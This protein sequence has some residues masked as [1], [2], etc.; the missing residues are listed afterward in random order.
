MSLEEQVNAFSAHLYLDGLPV[1]LNYQRLTRRLSDP[2]IARRERLD[3][4]VALAS[5]EG[6]GFLTLADHEDDT[7]L[8][9]RFFPKDRTY[10]VTAILEGVY[11]GKFVTSNRYKRHLHVSS[12]SDGFVFSVSKYGVDK[13]TFNDLANGPVYINLAV[14]NKL[15]YLARENDRLYFLD[16]DP[17]VSKH[18]AYNSVPASFVMKVVSGPGQLPDD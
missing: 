8:L 16:S 3:V 12:G 15:V 2:R 4:E 10:E 17:N 7:P 13:A 11:R 9:L 1:V 18:D 5:D 14:N 6:A